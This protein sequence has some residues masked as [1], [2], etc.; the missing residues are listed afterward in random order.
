MTFWRHVLAT[1]IATLSVVLSSSSDLSRVAAQ[2]AL[3]TGQVTSAEEG[4]L[5]GVVVSARKAGSTVTVSVISDAEGKFSFPAAKLEPGPYALKIRA[6]GYELDGPKTVE[7]GSA[8]RAG[9]DQAA[10]DPQS[11]RPAH[12]RRM[13]HEHAGHAGAEGVARP[14]HE[15]PHA[16]AAGEVDLRRRA[17]HRGAAAH[18][19]LRAR[20][21]R[22]SSPGSAVDVRADISPERLAPARRIS[23][24]DQ[25]QPERAM[26]LR[27]QDR[28]R[29]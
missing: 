23:R 26:G 7:V 24:L 4:N 11:G 16:R 27:A 2:S 10:Q 12:Q 15:L 9:F 22:R 21:A 6:I 28:C 8:D 3:L 25:S 20:D 19:Q 1:A 14:L 13:G 29:G 5:E 18:G 17:V